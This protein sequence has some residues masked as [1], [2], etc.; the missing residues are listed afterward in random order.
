MLYVN[1]S[2]RPFT[3]WPLMLRFLRNVSIGVLASVLAA[4]APS[5][6]APPKVAT[7]APAAALAVPTPKTQTPQNDPLVTASTGRIAVAP[8]GPV[9]VGLLLPLS[10]SAQPTGQGI[11]NAAQLALFEMGDN[12]LVLQVYDTQSTPEGATLA[13]NKAIAQG[14]QIL[15]GPVFAA[16]VK[17]VA[18]L[19]QAAGLN[20]VAFSTDPSVAA[21][22]VFVLSFLVEAQVREMIS[23]ARAQGLARFAVLAPDNAYGQSV[24]DN[25]RNLVPAA[26]G[27]VHQVALFEPSGTNLEETVRR[28]ADFDQRRAALNQ[29]RAKLASA[30]DEASQLALKRLEQLETFGDVAFDAIFI[31]E[32]GARL[33]QAATLLPFFD[34][35]TTRVQLLGTMLW[36]PRGLGRE[37]S[38]IGGLYPAPAPETSRDFAN[39]Y[40]NAFNAAP[41]PLANH[42]YD[43]VAL[44]AVLVRS[45]NPQPFSVPALTDSS[46]FS[47]VDGIFRFKANGMSE[48]SFAIMQITRDGADV[49]R[50]APIS[51]QD[52]QF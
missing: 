10:G 42:G 40:R 37:P 6:V 39:R 15:L 33:T 18:P 43:A 45:E 48:R 36:S 11:L 14:A 22:N 9:R 19:A 44:A 23:Y 38:L 13:V 26:G 20:V 17:A 32:Q 4:C 5:G 41:G 24:A 34:I 46:G 29:E 21:S 3:L 47:G 25:V 1:V 52:V 12:R 51:F 27:E 7:Q 28:L 16:E 31:P 50:P 30:T 2:N 35:D 49:V 8:G